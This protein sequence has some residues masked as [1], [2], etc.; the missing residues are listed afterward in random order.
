MTFTAKEVLKHYSNE[1]DRHGDQGTSTVMDMRTR[2]LEINAILLYLREGMKVLEV[3]C[4]NGYTSQYIVERIA[5]E[6]DATDFSQAMIGIAQ[7]RPTNLF[8]GKV[9]FSCQDI[10]LLDKDAV[11]DAVFTERCLQNLV[12]WEDQ[13]KALRNIA[14]ALKPGGELI[15]LESFLTGHTIL[16]EARR[17]LDLPE[18]PP[19]WHNL[20]FD[21]EETIKHMESLGCR[22]VDQNTFLSGYYFGSRLLLP[23]MMPEGKPVSSKSVL[24]NYFCHLPSHGDFCP[25][26]IVRFRKNC[27]D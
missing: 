15:M 12:S 17:E 8:L 4:G 13:K 19:S 18:I 5:V 23:A 3:G 25:L 20:F 27:R 11:Y 7:Q 2:Q 16:N 21:E 9:D 1:A 6:I 26:K 24:N 14:H 22:Y 10:L